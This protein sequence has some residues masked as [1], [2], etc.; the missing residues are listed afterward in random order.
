MNRDLRLI[1]GLAI[2]VTTALLLA[3]LATAIV[4]ASRP[5]ECGA[6]FYVSDPADC[7][8]HGGETE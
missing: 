6:P 7:P 2:M 4:R 8:R 5:C 1:N 3:A